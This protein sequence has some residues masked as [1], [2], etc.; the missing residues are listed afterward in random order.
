MNP[1]HPVSRT[2]LFEQVA[3]QIVR[4]VSEGRWKPGDKLP[5]EHELCKSFH[6]GRSTLREALRALAFAG[7][8]RMVPGEGS[9]VA[10]GPSNILG[11]ILAPGTLRT[12]KDLRDLF[13]T[14][15]ALEG[16]SAAL[17]AERASDAEIQNLER[18]ANELQ[19]YRNDP[20]GRDRE[21]DVA[22]H[23]AM[24]AASKN[25]LLAH[26]LQV[27]ERP[28]RELITKSRS[29]PDSANYAFEEHMAIVEALK[30]HDPRKARAAV[31]RHLWSFERVCEIIADAAKAESEG[32]ADHVETV[33]E[34]AN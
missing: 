27:L 28:L 25:Q 34:P 17:C 8:L 29:F 23:L 32:P 13:E 33:G 3:R 21:I 19:R 15:R 20:E 30:E 22:F 9:Y 31:E 7:M 24:A 26:L 18:L 5:A 4:I 10:V 11:H 1:L 6:V 16:E 14:R 2:S 12:E